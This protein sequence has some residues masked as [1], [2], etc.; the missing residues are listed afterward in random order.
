[1]IQFDEHMFQIG[2][3]HQL[4]LDFGGF[5]PDFEIEGIL[6]FSNLLWLNDLSQGFP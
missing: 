6:T 1:M 5:V 4:V 2:W 3:N